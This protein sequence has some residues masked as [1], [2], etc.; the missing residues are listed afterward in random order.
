[1][2]QADFLR[3]HGCDE[4]QGYLFARPMPAADFERAT[5]AT[6]DGPMRAIA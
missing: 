6:L 2:A 1:M 3:T 5:D 4:A